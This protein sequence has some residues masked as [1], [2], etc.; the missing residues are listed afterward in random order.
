[1]R[2]NCILFGGMSIGILSLERNEIRTV[3]RHAIAQMLVNSPVL[4]LN[5]ISTVN[6]ESVLSVNVRR[7]IGNTIAGVV[8]PKPSPALEKKST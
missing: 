5:A 8:P 4:I 2:P 3:T 1:L 7:S 6:I